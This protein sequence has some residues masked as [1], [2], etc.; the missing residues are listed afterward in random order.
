MENSRTP[1]KKESKADKFWNIFL[2]TKNGKLK[3]TLIVNSFSLSLLFMAIYGLSYL[4]LID[5]LENMLAA[6][7]GVALA[8]FAESAVPALA[9]TVLCCSLFF[10]FRDKRLVPGAYVWLLL[11]SLRAFLSA[12][13]AAERDRGVFLSLYGMIVPAP[14]ILGGGCSAYLYENAKRKNHR[15][16]NYRD[17]RGSEFNDQYRSV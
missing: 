11:F 6:R 12:R 7:Y 10:V 14:L 15:Y 5:P 13:H 16:R 3:S 9:G 17:G 2:F 8:S 1:E 4:M